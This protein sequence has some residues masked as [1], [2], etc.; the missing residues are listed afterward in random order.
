MR[1]FQ[2]LKK[3]ESETDDL[4]KLSVAEKRRYD[5][6]V[7]IQRYLSEGYSPKTIRG[8]LRTTYNRIRR[9][10]KG[11]PYK[12]CRFNKD[13]MKKVNYEHYREDIVNYLRHNI[14]FKD[15]C[16][17]ITADGY[18]GKLTQVKKYCHKLI[19][20]LGI[21]HTSKKNTAG[22]Y[23][24][25]DQKTSIHYV[26]SGTIF[27]FLWSGIEIDEKDLKYIF[28]KYPILEEIHY[29]IC[30]FRNIYTQKDAALLEQYIETYKNCSIDSLKSF[31]NGLSLDIDA[32]KNS[33]ISD[34]SN[35]FVEGINNKI[36][37]IKRIMFGRA[38]LDLLTAKI[39][40]ANWT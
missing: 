40:H 2:F 9:Y 21:E 33:V 16:A 22:V 35:G 1:S 23:I 15:I 32:V 8:L 5:D 34:L 36:K 18:N 3:I 19:A 6:I 27:K 26:S 12:M 29:S 25:K 24:K 13:G 10:A 38:K 11:D 14:S 7:T 31:A 39:L 37:V 4:S 17:R 30:D 20:E 28:N